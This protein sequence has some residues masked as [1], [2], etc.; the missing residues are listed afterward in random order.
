MSIYL[1]RFS[2]AYVKRVFGWSVRVP[3][4]G[5][6]QLGRAL[7]THRWTTALCIGVLRNL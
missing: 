2:L 1:L 3:L 4:R 5:L 6:T 7:R